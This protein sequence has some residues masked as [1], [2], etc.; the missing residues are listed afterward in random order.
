[1]GLESSL[2]STALK[3]LNNLPWCRAENVSGDSS[4]SGRPDINGCINGIAFRLELKSTDHK[5]MASIKQKLDLRRWYNCGAIVGVVYSME[6]LKM[7]FTEE[8]LS[9]KKLSLMEQ[10]GCKSWITLKPYQLPL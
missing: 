4:Q 1:M 8:G 9:L 5:N 2:Q 10:N 6:A 3:Y 7:W